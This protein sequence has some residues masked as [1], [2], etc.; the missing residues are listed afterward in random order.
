MIVDTPIIECYVRKSHLSGAPSFSKDDELI[1]AILMGIRFVR[2][3]SPLFIVYIPSVGAVYDKV[4]QNAI[5][6][7]PEL[8][9]E[10][11][12]DMD[13]VAWWDCLSTNWQ[14]IQLKYLKYAEVEM[15]TRNKEEKKGIYLFTCDPQEPQ[16]GND[17]GES[18][19]WHEHKTKTFFFDYDTGVLC[20][21]PNNKMRIWN[22]SLTPK[23][24]DSGSWLRVYQ[25]TPEVMSHYKYLKKEKQFLGDSDSFDYSEE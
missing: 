15:T 10:G 14:L 12:I 2:Y 16:Y 13:D 21:T 25:E 22:G 11:V 19:I 17:Y 7:K 5:F 3:R 9:F 23:D 24:K 20:C 4:N 8:D 18:Q 6:N 1:F